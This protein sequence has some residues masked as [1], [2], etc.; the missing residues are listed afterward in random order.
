LN[1]LNA[2]K[3]DIDADK[4]KPQNF[5]AIRSTL[6]KEEFTPEILRGKSSAAAGLCDW[7]INISTYYDV[8]VSVEP[9]KQK[10]AA[11]KEELAAANE[12]KETM[13]AK[14]AELSAKL[15]I[16]QADFQKAMDEKNRAEAEANRCAKRLDSAN[17]LVNAL[18][19]ELERWSNSIVQLG[20]DLEYVTGDVL[21]ASAFVSYVGPFN[22]DF[23]EKI[24]NDNF[25]K[26]FKDN[27]IPSSPVIDPLAIL[28]TEAQKAQWNTEKLPSDQVSAENGCILTSSD[29]YSLM[30][31]PQ[32]QGIQ[33]IRNKEAANNLESTRLTPETMN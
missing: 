24:I 15:A 27:K 1:G 13:E 17:R 19:S 30:I 16:L 20:Q 7:V 22:K 3:G 25:I 31:D 18:G 6:E 28:T 14:V 26:F 21:M 33:W 9:K 32:L 10:V 8:F 29:R 4:V 5:A 11:A 12:K 2:F 23:R